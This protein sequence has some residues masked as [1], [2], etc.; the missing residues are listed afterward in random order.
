MNGVSNVEASAVRVSEGNGAMDDRLRAR[1]PSGLASQRRE[2]ML[3]DEFQTAIFRWRAAVAGRTV[4]AADER[5]L[6][7]VFD[8]A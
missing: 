3:A 5:K 8:A 6:H 2:Q 4:P 1:L 7:V